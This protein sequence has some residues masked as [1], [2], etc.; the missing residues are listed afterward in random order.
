MKPE[1]PATESVA[2][3]QVKR[4]LKEVVGLD[5][6][7]VFTIFAR[8][9]QSAAG[10]ITIFLIARLLSPV[11]Q[12]YYYTFVSLVALQIVFELGFSFVIQ[13]MASHERANL[14]I[15]AN[16]E[17]G[18]DPVAHARLA[19]VLQ[20]TVRWYSI[21]AVLMV[22]SLIFAGFYF[23]SHHQRGALDAGWKIPW[24][25]VALAA[26][27]TFQIDPI[28]AFLEGC[29][30]V[31]NVARLRMGQA[32]LGSLLAWSALIL[33][34]GLYAP[35]MMITGIATTGIAWLY[36]RRHFLLSLLRYDPGEH[37]IQ[38]RTEVWPFQWKIAVSWI[39]SYFIFQ[40]FNPV[41]FAYRGAVSAG[42]M[43]MSLNVASALQTIA[44]SWINT[45]SAPFG[46][47]IARKQYVELDRIFFRSLRQS[48]TVCAIGAAILLAALTFINYRNI[49]FSH[50]LLP[51]QD[52]GLL[53]FAV[54]AN[55]VVF[56]EALYLRAHK[57]EKFLLNSIL[58]ALFVAASTLYLGRLYG[59]RGM[60]VGYLTTVLVISLG[61]G[62]Y[63]FL[64]YRKIWHAE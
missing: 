53:F 61:Q 6:A 48:V 60:I 7:I 18:G 3:I 40:L 62:T 45:K 46:T 54:I 47:M 59:A 21:A 50:R 19:S 9:W 51:A 4:W 23:F 35:A 17:V 52:L 57:Q 39:S 36:R 13:Q 16:Y 34:H 29:G 32:V 15:S 56:A 26:S 28:L 12:G 1:N 8:V 41:L 5:R 38:W 42:Q 10:L 2:I 22:G 43:G 14:T 20:K 64:K 30:Y 24:C 63:T 44:I 25:C 27:I 49:P 11:Q 55:I 37:I 31:A 58:T 33:H